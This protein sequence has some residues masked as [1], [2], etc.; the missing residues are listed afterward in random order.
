MQSSL[1]SIRVLTVIIGVL[2]STFAWSIEGNLPNR[3]GSRPVT[4]S[5][6]SLIQIAPKTDPRIVK[7]LLLQ[8]TEL[9]GVEL[10]ESVMSLPGAKGF[11]LKTDIHV[12]RPNALVRGR[13]FAHIQPD[14]SLHASIAPTLAILNKKTLNTY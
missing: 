10:H 6:V 7:K 4:T 11:W 1:R 8:V 5:N 14:G 12:A 9:S 3:S 13:E 2:S